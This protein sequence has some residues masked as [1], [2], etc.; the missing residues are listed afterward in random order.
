MP[1]KS[2]QR[3]YV[4]WAILPS[5]LLGS[6]LG[7]DAQA[8]AT[9]AVVTQTTELKQQPSAQAVNVMQLQAQQQVSI[10]SRQGGWYQVE[11][12]VGANA[13][14]WIPLFFVRFAA[15]PPTG[16]ALKLTTPVQVFKSTQQVTSTTGVRGLNRGDIESS[17]GDFAAFAVMQTYQVA[18]LATAEF[19]QMAPLQANPDIV[20]EKQP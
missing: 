8:V 12:T 15:Q 10:Q 9:N 4:R 6:S 14:G 2:K 7:G 19:A 11:T 1:M 13:Q 20:L 5:L 18:A 17:T 3:G 16:S